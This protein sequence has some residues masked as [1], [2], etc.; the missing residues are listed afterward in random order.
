[1]KNRAV[2]YT[3]FSL[4][5][6][7]LVVTTMAMVENSSA[8]HNEVPINDTK[9]LYNGPFYDG[10]EIP[11][12]YKKNITIGYLTSLRGP[13]NSGKQGLAISGALTYAL[14]KVS[15]HLASTSW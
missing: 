11:I 12:T 13:P 4:F 1:M 6:V 3:V 5:H 8:G 2:A 15:V 7:L 14:D 9:K 10:T